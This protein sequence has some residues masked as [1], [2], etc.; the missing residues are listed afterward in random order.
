MLVAMVI[1]LFSEMKADWRWRIGRL[2]ALTAVAAVGLFAFRSVR[3]T[4]AEQ[5]AFRIDA[6]QSTGGQPVQVAGASR[7]EA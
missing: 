3:K 6:S 4:T 1:D 2:S 7:T 5:L